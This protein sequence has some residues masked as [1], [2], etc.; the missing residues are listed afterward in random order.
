MKN[1]ATPKEVV[2]TADMLGVDEDS[3]YFDAKVIAL[4]VRQSRE[5]Q[6]MTARHAQT[7]VRTAL[8]AKRDRK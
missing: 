2:L 5:L 8:V 1:T 7:L 4:I 6:E 3:H